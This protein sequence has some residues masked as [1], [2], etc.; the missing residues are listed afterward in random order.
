MD[1]IG[2]LLLEF[3]IAEIPMTSE[4]IFALAVNPFLDCELRIESLAY[5]AKTINTRLDFSVVGYY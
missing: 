4:T 3:T 5:N 2:M 1:L